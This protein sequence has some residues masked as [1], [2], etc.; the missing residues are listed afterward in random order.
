MKKRWRQPA[1]LAALVMMI[2]G[3]A[4]LGEIVQEPRLQFKKV[5][6]R[7]FSLADAR[8]D[9]DFD[10]HNPNPL[11]LR[12]SQVTYNLA[13]N[14]HPLVDGTVN[15]GIA[16]PARGSAPLTLPV[17]LNFKD[18]L[19]A[20]GDMGS[21]PKLPY[22]LNG[23]VFVGPLAIPY[24][25]EG[26]LEL[27]RLPKIELAGVQIRELSLSGAR[28]ACQVRMTNRNAI[29]LDLGKLVYQLQLGDIQVAA[30]ETAP[31]APLKA[32][33]T[34]RLS[35][36]TRIRFREVGMG[37]LKLLQGGTTTAYTLQ[38]SFSQPLPGGGDHQIPF[39][40]S[41]KTPLKR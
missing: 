41:G 8:F 2:S 30:G 12:L 19:A 13:L 21:S 28:L 24:D 14:R 37:L 38:G 10:V 36:D 25:V 26:E 35:L 1:L 9:F 32:S 4:G 22:Q 15:E 33:G 17:R 11:G 6:P 39:S 18:L 29:P 34:D 3:C 16:L 20:V 31:L 40:F 7:A 23:K 5:T 27:P